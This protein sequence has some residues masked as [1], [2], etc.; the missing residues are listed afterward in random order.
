MLFKYLAVIKLFWKLKSFLVKSL[1]KL[2]KKKFFLKS[3]TDTSLSYSF[4]IVAKY[5]HVLMF[6][7][8]VLYFILI[9][10]LIWTEGMIFF[11][12]TKL[13]CE[14]FTTKPMYYLNLQFDITHP[15]SWDELLVPFW[16]VF[17]LFNYIELI[18]WISF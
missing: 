1:N 14:I 4:F 15:N 5:I 10:G 18:L 8:K 17:G 7:L 12:N 16:K 3:E 2:F 13:F 9:S 11:P 6:C